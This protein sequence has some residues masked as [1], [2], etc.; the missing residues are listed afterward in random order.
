[1][2]R[3]V[4][5][6]GI[7]VLFL[8]APV[9]ASVAE[10]RAGG[11]GFSGGSRGSRSYSVPRTPSAPV[12]PSSPATSTAAPAQR[13]GGLLG[14]LGGMLGGF[15]LG[16][17]LGSLLFGGLGNGLGFG[18]LELV[19]VG[20]LVYLAFAF[21]RRRAPE[22]AVAGMPGRSGWAPPPPAAEPA[23]MASAG[24]AGGLLDQDLDTGIEAIRTMDRSFDPDRLA[25]QARAGFL[26]V[27]A[28]WSA[29]DLSPVR[30][31]FTDE[32]AA[33]LEAQLARLRTLRRANRI[34]Q[35]TVEAAE[36]TEAWQEY[37][38]DFVTVRLRATALDYTVDEATGAVVDGSRSAPTTFEEYWTFARPVG[39]QAWRLSA[40]QQPA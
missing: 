24:P 39:P 10:A 28:A 33:S 15:L 29:G 19:L 17:L 23:R 35:V 8:T 11:R 36:V 26:R 40:I 37:G 7:L 38:R 27:Q 16:G 34:E 18:L 22:P 30:A 4:I 12:R 6:C 32:M 21:F 9:L 3:G 25:E 5:A 13:P 1:M 31:E 2:R 20:G 14:G